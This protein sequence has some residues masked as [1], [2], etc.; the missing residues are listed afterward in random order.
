MLNKQ[1]EIILQEKLDFNK[2]KDNFEEQK[3]DFKYIL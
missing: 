2:L 3:Y 1:K